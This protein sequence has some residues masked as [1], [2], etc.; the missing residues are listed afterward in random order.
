MKRSNPIFRARL[1][2]GKQI[3]D[4]QL[5][6]AVEFGQLVAARR[7]PEDVGRAADPATP[8]ELVDLARAK[9]LDVEGVSRDEMFQ[10]FE[11]LRRAVEAVGAAADGLALGTRW[12][13]RRIRG[14]CR[15]R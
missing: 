8:D 2:G 3:A 11:P 12:P 9:P 13:E 6:I 5:A 7:Q 10:P 15:G 1:D 4:R 14:S